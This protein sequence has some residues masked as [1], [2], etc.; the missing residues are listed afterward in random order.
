MLLAENR[1]I[2]SRVVPVFPTEKWATKPTIHR[3]TSTKRPKRSWIIRQFFKNL[4][5]GSFFIPTV[6]WAINRFTPVRAFYCSLYG[7]VDHGDGTQTN[8]GLLGRR[9]VTDAGVAFLAADMAGGGSDIN[10]FKYHGFGTG[11]TAESAAHT[12]LVTELTTEYA[13]DNTRPTGSQGSATNVYTTV[14]TLS[15]DSNVA[16]TEHG[17]FSQ[18][19]TGGGTMWDRT[20][21]SAINLVGSVD[22][23]Q[24]THAT[25]FP[26]GG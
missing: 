9:L 7:V 20:V 25:T 6:A 24:A 22:S 5:D 11:T 23:L 19:A 3:E 14:G 17:I 1:P 12:A 10:L 26:S 4:F 15:P 2:R 18:A 13:S 8:Y 21:F 16:I